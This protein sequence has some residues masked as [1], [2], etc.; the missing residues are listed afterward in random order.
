MAAISFF[1]C[2]PTWVSSFER[3]SGLAGANCLAAL[4]TRAPEIQRSGQLS[5][6]IA[7][8]GDHQGAAAVN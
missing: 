4:R 3:C 5:L 7:G 1:C 2:G 8:Y 6:V